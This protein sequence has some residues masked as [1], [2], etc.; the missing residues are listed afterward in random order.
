[1][2]SPVPYPITTLQLAHRITGAL[3]NQGVPERFRT[4]LITHI[5]QALSQAEAHQGHITPQQLIETLPP[6][7]ILEAAEQLTARAY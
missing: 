5:F 1:M 3:I 2:E 4:L 7:T 6:E